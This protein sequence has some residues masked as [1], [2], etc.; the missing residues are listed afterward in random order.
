MIMATVQKSLSEG[1]K[2]R[3]DVLKVKSMSLKARMSEEEKGG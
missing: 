1:E 3:Y 2:R